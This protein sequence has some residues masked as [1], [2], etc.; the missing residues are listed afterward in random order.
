MAPALSRSWLRAALL[1]AVVALAYANTLRAPFLFDDAGA[2]VNNPTIRSLTSLAVL[3]PPADGSTT[4]GRPVVNL[5]YALNYTV[6]GEAVWSYHAANL[7]IHALAALALLG[8]VRRTLL[9][10]L[11]R[12][13]YGPHASSLAFFT[14]LLWALPPLQTE[15][16][17]CIA[18][19]T[20]SLCGL[21]YL[22]TLYAFVRFAPCHVLSDKAPAPLP[23]VRHAFSDI[24]AS[25]LPGA[26]HAI[27]DKNPGRSRRGWAVASVAACV[28]GMGTKEVM[29]TA[30]LVVLLYDRTFVAGSFAAA[31]RRRRPY[32]AA[33]A[34]SWGLLLGLQVQT[35]GGRGAAAGFGRG[36]SSW[37]YLLT[38]CEALLH[39]LRL[40]LWP[41]P[42]VLDYGT[43]VVHSV[44]DVW[45]QGSLIL[46]LLA[47]TAWALVRKP[48]VGFIGAWFFLILAPSS[49]IVP[50][51]TQ[52]IAEHRLYLPLAALTL[53]AVAAAHL[54]F[55]CPAPWIAG[56]LAVALAAGTVARNRDYRD[57]INIWSSSVA[58]Y[59][60]SA[61]AQNNLGQALQEAGHAAEADARFARAV[62]LDSSYAAARYNWGV[63]LLAGNRLPA[64]M[65]Q[66][67]AAV[68]LAPDHADAQFNLGN[69]L[70]RAQRL[71]EALP[72]FERAL[73][74]RPAADVHFN[75]GLTLAELKRDAAAET[76]LRAAL[77]LDPTL[78]EAY[79]QLGR[80]AERGGRGDQALTPYADTLRYAP[81][82]TGAHQRLAL[83][84]AQREDFP[85][86]AGHCR[87]LIRIHPFDA[88][89]HANLGNVLLLQG[90]SA[91]AIASY[92]EALRLRPDDRRIRES[93]RL[94]RESRP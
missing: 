86:A 81:E 39:Y 49:S 6:S 54:R 55:P 90:Q 37:H 56:G 38:Q 14:A 63:A 21:F 59:P 16:V 73:Q 40:A 57:A 41:H 80:L 13:V 28:A 25:L 1:I 9:L 84:L 8:L 45:W 20:E 87:A 94:A 53:A 32:Y 51:V 10:P 30:P 12:P 77:Q 27:S 83:L 70:V 79:Y 23:E 92:E 4:T 48:V 69:A 43:T 31:C 47:G 61:R 65:A 85:A 5:S 88:D 24:R 11:L 22:L 71:A 82:H 7:A 42:L 78:A 76:H 19:R 35:G 64:A 91:A 89:A 62:A 2:V 29:V 75:L 36:V 3:H 72:H 50:L 46:L 44:T 66:L 34:A 52:T 74:L 60:S 26:W 68:Q 58:A 93:L 33:L 18:Q 67:E 15:S 17:T